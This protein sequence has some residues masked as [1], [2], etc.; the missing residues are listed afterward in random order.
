MNGTVADS[1]L[2]DAVAL[3]TEHGYRI[4]APRRAV[5]C[6][7]LKKSCS[8]TAE[9][10][11]AE[12]PGIGR[13]T[14]YRTLEILASLDVLARLLQPGG[15]PAYVV[16]SPGHRHHLVCSECGSVVA[17]TRCPVDEFLTD[18]GRDTE[19]AIQGHHLEIFGLCRNCQSHRLAS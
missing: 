1:N 7:V 4:T 3:L 18:L 14:I 19:F 13:S 11:V 12:I 9:Q 8:F 6:A 16:G 15:H 17:F 10:L 2:S 5:I